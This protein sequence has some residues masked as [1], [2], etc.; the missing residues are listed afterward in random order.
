MMATLLG[1]GLNFS[2]LL[3]LD[4]VF[5]DVEQYLLTIP[6]PAWPFEAPAPASVAA[7]RAVFEATCAPCHGVYHGPKANC[8]N[9]VVKLSDIGTDPLRVANFGAK[10]AAVANQLIADPNHAMVPSGGYLAQP[11]VGIWATA[12]YLHNGS[13]PDLRGVIDSSARPKRWRRHGEG[14]AAY[15]RVAMGWAFVVV[16]GSASAVAP[17]ATIEARKV[18]ETSHPGMSNAGH[19][20]GD[21]LDPGQRAALL[22][23]LKTL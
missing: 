1:L 19:T 12:P 15:D 20:Y 23:Y 7:G 4:G 5:S 22:D 17:P 11:L 6:A 13:V 10:E 21:A 16:D 8:P 9:L 14:D 2:Q 18:V 3:A